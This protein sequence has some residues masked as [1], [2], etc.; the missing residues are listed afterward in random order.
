MKWKQCWRQ[1]RRFSNPPCP[2]LPEII[3]LT[4][5]C[6]IPWNVLTK[7][8]K[9]R[10]HTHKNTD[11][12]TSCH[13]NPTQSQHVQQKNTELWSNEIENKKTNFWMNFS[14]CD[15]VRQFENHTDTNGETS[16]ILSKDRQSSSVILFWVEVRLFQKP[17]KE[18]GVFLWD[19]VALFRQSR[20]VLDCVLDC[21]SRLQCVDCYG[22]HILVWWNKGAGYID[23]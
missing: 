7:W 1:I 21:F 9:Q 6:G 16:S 14:Q 15:Q 11:S 8:G 2:F 22:D 18:F 12:Q 10:H 20:C 3:W 19:S 17:G 13:K 5:R 23:L 4:S